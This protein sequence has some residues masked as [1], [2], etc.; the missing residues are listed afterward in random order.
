MRINDWRRKI[1]A[2]DTALLHLL[3]LRAELALEVG[4][5]KGK[6]GLVLRVPARELEILNRMKKENPGPL[7][8]GAITKIYQMILSESIRFQ[9]SE[10]CG[11][12]EAAQ[13]ERARANGRRRGVPVA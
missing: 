11:I 9:E 1:D 8:D 4:R 5:L 10:G 7:G 6:K 12:S 13:P 2:I 3:N